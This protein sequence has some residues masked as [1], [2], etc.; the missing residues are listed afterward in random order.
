MLT[1]LS[2]S[3]RPLA[4]AA[5]GVGLLHCGGKN[6]TPNVTPNPDGG[7]PIVIPACSGGGSPALPGSRPTA[8]ACS[9]TPNYLPGSPEVSCTTLADCTDGGTTS[10]YTACRGGKCALDQCL[11]DSD[12]PSGQACGCAGQFG[13][14][15]I[16]T[17]AC[18][19]AQ[20]RV[21]SDCDRSVGICSPTKGYC[22][23]LLGYYCHTAEDSC[24]T[25]A[26][27]CDQSIP[28]CQYQPSLGHFACQAAIGCNG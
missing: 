7:P 3:L 9:V 15:A 11:T 17:N 8:V 16:H 21:N 19:P 24:I 22:G 12:C 2:L 25:D 1:K 26:D 20:C 14:N 27:C 18:V 10:P 23:N 28:S 4:L 6:H 13:G 5:F